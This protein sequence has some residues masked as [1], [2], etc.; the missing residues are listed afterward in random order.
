MALDRLRGRVPR[1]RS[2]RSISRSRSSARPSDSRSA[3]RAIP[4][5]DSRASGIR[6]AGSVST[7]GTR[8]D[9]L[10]LQA[11][12]RLQ[13]RRRRTT[14][15]S[16]AKQF[17]TSRSVSRTC[18]GSASAIS[19]TGNPLQLQGLAE[20]QARA[21]ARGRSRRT[22]RTGP[23]ETGT[24][25]GSIVLVA[26]NADATF[27]D[28]T[29]HSGPAVSRARADARA[30]GT[31]RVDE[32]RVRHAA[33]ARR[34]SR[35]R[36]DR[37]LGGRVARRLAER[38]EITIYASRPPTVAAPDGTASRYRL[39]PH[40]ARPRRS[41]RTQT[42]MAAASADR[43]FFA[44]VFHPLEYWTA[45][46]RATSGAQDST[47]STSST[48]RRHCRFSG[49]SRGA[50]LVLHMHCEWLTQLDGRMIDRRL[51]HADLIVGCS[52][53]ITD[54]V[55]ERFPQHA[56]RC[57]TIYNGVDVEHGGR[58]RRRPRR[59]PIRLLNV[60]RVSA[61]EGP[62]RA[63]RRT[64]ARRRAR[65][66]RPTDDPRR[67]VAGP[68]RVRGED[69]GRPARPATWPAS[70]AAATCSTFASGCRPAVAR[71]A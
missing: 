28:V 52:D 27:G 1:S 10:L 58:A 62:P 22:F 51:R 7:P 26:H 68:V 44:S 69:L 55:R 15:S 42:R 20:R 12:A 14:R 46:R 36:L 3:G 23:G 65:T 11:A 33:G 70:T 61:G 4:T 63:R 60:G 29:R 34:A 54:K 31:R 32:D 45:G 17:T 49:G 19:A 71:S 21:R 40:G 38:H 16:L 64:R 9:P 2:T 5:G 43:P 25:P 67:G 56:D 47:S 13:P 50:K 41:A 37:A 6:P 66:R 24:H 59:T 53:H 18:S 8:A 39:V 30:I 57:V 35:G 48:T